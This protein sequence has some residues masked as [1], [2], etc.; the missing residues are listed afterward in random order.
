[1]KIV[2]NIP[3]YNEAATIAAVIAA[4]PDMIQGHHVIVQVV[5]DGSQ[6]NTVAV[7][8]KA[9]AK[10][11]LSH[12]YNQGVGAAFRTGVEHFLEI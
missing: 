1:M 12:G 3:A 10:H 7:A 8:Q 11:V 9:G 5:N 4:I 2:V 6:D